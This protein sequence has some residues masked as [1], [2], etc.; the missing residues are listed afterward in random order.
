MTYRLTSKVVV[1]YG[2]KALVFDVGDTFILAGNELSVQGDSSPF[3]YGGNV[4]RLPNCVVEPLKEELHEITLTSNVRVLLTIAGENYL[5]HWYRP[6][7]ETK[8]KSGYC[9]LQLHTFMK[10]F[11]QI[12]SA[13]NHQDKYFTKIFIEL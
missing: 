13:T 2:V 5:P 11:G 8:D 6:I 9:N 7:L 10:V 4:I 3:H 1:Y 12:V